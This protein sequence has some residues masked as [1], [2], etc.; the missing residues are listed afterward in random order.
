MYNLNL[1]YN[2]L[3]EQYYNCFND[4]GEI[5][6]EE[7]FYE[8]TLK[9]DNL[10]K[11]KAK[12]IE[13]LCQKSKTQDYFIDNIKEEIERLK[14]MKEKLEKQQERTLIFLKDIFEKDYKGKSEYYW[15]FNLNLRKSE[16][17]E[18]TEPNIIDEKYKKISYTFDKTLIKKDIKEWIEVSGANLQNKN[19][20]IIW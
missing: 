19:N 12:F 6:N 9:L 16:S 15:T 10:K 20:L 17:I 1:E 13:Y 5:I 11:E 7:E 4:D 2:E 3:M 8:I 14:K 18:I